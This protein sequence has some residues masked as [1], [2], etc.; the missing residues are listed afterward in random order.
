MLNKN[1]SVYQV[2]Y[3]SNGKGPDGKK[4]IAQCRAWRDWFKESRPGYRWIDPMDGE[5]LSTL[6]N[7]G[8]ESNVQSAAMV[9]RDYTSVRNADII[10]INTDTFGADRPLIGSIF[11]IAWAWEFKKPIIMISKDEYYVKHPFLKTVCSAV[12]KNQ[13]AALEV[14]DYIVKG[15]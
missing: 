3:I 11:E 9:M 15:L 7:H 4:L 6:K 12:V 2:G 13:E 5:D 14:L 10:I 1:P 8:L